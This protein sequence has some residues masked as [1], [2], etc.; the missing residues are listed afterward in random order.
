MNK[1]TFPYMG[2]YTFAFKTL[3]GIDLNYILTKPNKE[4]I[5]IGE[6]YS[7]ECMCFPYKITL[8]NIMENIN[9]GATHAFMVEM[10][11]RYDEGE[12]RLG[13]YPLL[14]EIV[15]KNIGHDVNFK[16]VLMEKPIGSLRK[17]DPSVTFFKI[18][19]NMSLFFI[20][21]YLIDYLNK[22]FYR[23]KARANNKNEVD[24]LKKNLFSEI[25][26]NNN[27]YRLF[28]LKGKIKR[29]FKKI[30]V[31]KRDALRVGIF[32]EIYIVNELSINNDVGDFLNKRG[33]EVDILTTLSDTLRYRYVTKGLEI[34]KANKIAGKYVKGHLGGHGQESA[35]HIMEAKEHNYDGL[36]HLSPFGCMPEVSVRPILNRIA[37][38]KKVNFLSLSLDE[39][40]GRAGLETRLEAFIDMIK[41]QKSISGE[42]HE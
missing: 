38:D 17:A 3:F 32:G 42:I 2:D 20:K 9:K 21:V 36:I 19:K 11:V 13:Y 6:K 7:P 30:K 34:R 23:I 29:L 14:Q 12:C 22:I 16:S 5:E 40:T 33:V 10:H 1:Y 35:V 24:N 25:D 26:K 8:G 18:Y 39:Q 31:K 4:T 37:K 27:I 15:L 41:Q 28:M